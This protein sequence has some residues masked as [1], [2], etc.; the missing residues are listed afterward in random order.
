MHARSQ[1]D[2]AQIHELMDQFHAYLIKNQLKSTRQRD[3]IAQTFFA[4][5]GHISIEDLLNLTRSENPRIGYATV[6]RT[7]KLLTECGLA[8]LRRFGDGQT[9]YETAGDTEHHDHL[10]CIECG[11]VLE[12]QNEQIEQEQERVARSFGFSLVRHRLELYGLCPRARGIKGGSCPH[13]DGQAQ[14][15]ARNGR[16][17]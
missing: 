13:D 12:F 8:A 15:R 9:M 17:R 4:T 5:D 2:E 3:L 16:A 6:Y 10:I 14:A 7:L 11:H 1:R